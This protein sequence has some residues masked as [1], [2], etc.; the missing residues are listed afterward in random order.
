MDS[1]SAKHTGPR[2][3][4]GK[5]KSSKNALKHGLRGQKLLLPD[6][7][8]NDFVELVE[9]LKLKF[10]AQD[11]IEIALCEN[12]AM[13]IWKLGRY[14]RLEA[15]F[16]RNK[17]TV[18]DGYTGIVYI[19]Q[20]GLVSQVEKSGDVFGGLMKNTATEVITRYLSGLE[21]S[22]FRGIDLILKYKAVREE[23]GSQELLK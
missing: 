22:I 18:P 1:P 16:L 10:S 2:S 11:E 8:E 4:K 6:E 3:R 7:S 15:S 21:K 5:I 19:P 17:M 12:L 23:E 13:A 9:Q 14:H 20:N